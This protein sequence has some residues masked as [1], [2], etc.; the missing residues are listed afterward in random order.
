MIKGIF[1]QVE[2]KVGK[3]PEIA[4]NGEEYLVGKSHCS[5]LSA[6]T[7]TREGIESASRKVFLF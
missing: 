1:L 2:K 6:A 4:E 7:V 3:E 5:P